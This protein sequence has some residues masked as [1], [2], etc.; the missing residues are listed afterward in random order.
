MHICFFNRTYAP[1]V[2]ATGE[3]LAELAEDLVGEHGCRVSIIC[4]TTSAVPTVSAQITESESSWNGTSSG[5]KRLGVLNSETRNG[6]E[7]FRARSTRFSRGRFPGRFA[8]Y[9]SY[10][11]SASWASLRV[12]PPD[13]VVA[14]TD[15]PI[16]GLVGWATARRTGARFVFLCQD[17]FPEVAVLLQDFR[18]ELVNGLLQ[19][20]NRFLLR[21]AD[22][23]VAIGETDA[24]STRRRQ[25]GPPGARFRDSQL[26]GPVPDRAFVEGRELCP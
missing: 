12:S 4:G 1:D 26:G 3:L 6:V 19:R 25:R 8:N 10:F 23:V 15:P 20:I 7:V 16:I 9:V 2:G 5:G 11:L 14:L 24:A 17:V 13:V 22:R 18:S 21:R